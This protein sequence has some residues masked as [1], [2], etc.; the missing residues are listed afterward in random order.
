MKKSIQSALYI[1]LAVFIFACSGGS[2]QKYPAGSSAPSASLNG[3]TTHMQ[4]GTDLPWVTWL[5]GK[6]LNGADFNVAAI[7]KGDE[8]LRSRQWVLALKE[9]TSVRAAG[10]SFAQKQA[11]AL[12]ISTAELQLGQPAGALRTISDFYKAEKLGV[13]KVDL[14]SALIFAYAYGASADFDQSLAWFSRSRTVAEARYA[15]GDYVARGVKLL[16]EVA[17]SNQFETL[18]KTWHSDTFINTEIGRERAR[19]ARIGVVDFSVPSQKRFWELPSQ[20]VLVGAGSSAASTLTGVNDTALQLKVGVVVPLSGKYGAFGQSLKNGMELALKAQKSNGDTLPYSI[21]YKDSGMDLDTA[22]KSALDLITVDKAGFILGA[23]L[24]ENSVVVA[25][26]ARENRVPVISFSK[27]SNFETGSGVF[28]LGPTPESQIDS[29][30][31]ECY[32]RLGLRKFG[33]VYP[34]EPGALEFVDIFKAKLRDLGVGFEYEAKYY[35]DDSNALLTIAKELDQ[36]PGIEAIFFPDGLDAASKFSADLS[37][38]VRERT[39]L[40]GTASWDNYQELARYRTTMSG[41]IFVS[42]FFSLSERDITK[43]FVESY[44]KTYNKAPD[45]LAAQGFDAAT[46]VLAALK[47]QVGDHVSALEAFAGIEKYQGLTGDIQI[48]QGGELRRKFNVVQ[49]VGENLISPPEL[50]GTGTGEDA[51]LALE[52]VRPVITGI[53]GGELKFSEQNETDSNKN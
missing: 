39:R 51:H 11:L 47:R 52:N 34:T 3:G 14:P 38:K 20:S 23:L 50:T 41:A 15:S 9:F 35:T 7:L 17:S 32:H 24:S 16:L 5:D 48:E 26:L 33:M 6:D 42:P 40:I 10:L 13:D 43:S 19:R 28:R 30:I 31:E 2:K 44:K 1:L 18:A 22:R 4:I 36:Q 12:R 27:S 21:V 49:L 8:Y 37:P 29:L 46:L 45:F 25:D 53:G